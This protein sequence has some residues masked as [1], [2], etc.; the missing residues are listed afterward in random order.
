MKVSP[1]TSVDPA[2]DLFPEEA[3]LLLRLAFVAI[4]RRRFVA[5]DRILTALEA[6]RPD[7]EPLLVARVVTAMSQSA[8]AQ[9]R[10]LLEAAAHRQ[11]NLS[12]WLQVFYGIA[13]EKTGEAAAARRC[14]QAVVAQGET[15]LAV[16]F[17]QDLLVTEA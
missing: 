2:F 10:V 4:G 6:F 15:P 12:P 16:R 13:L 8:F 14:W 5:A 1:A 7:A 17:A 3:Q 11:G 9:S